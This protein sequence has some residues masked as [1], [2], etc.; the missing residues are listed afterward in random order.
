MGW[1]AVTDPAASFTSAGHPR[2]CHGM[3]RAHPLTGQGGQDR[4]APAPAAARPTASST[5]GRPPA[6]TPAAPTDAPAPE[7]IRSALP[8][9][10]TPGRPDHAPLTT[11]QPP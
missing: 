11:G 6:A 10:G 7:H 2:R 4:P 8:I 1:Q 9:R 5:C 3:R